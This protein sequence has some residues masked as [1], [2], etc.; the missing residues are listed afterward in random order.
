MYVVRK[1]NA[2][3]ARSLY[4]PSI[5]Q[6]LFVATSELSGSSST[7]QTDDKSLRFK[8]LLTQLLALKWWGSFKLIF[9]VTFGNNGSLFFLL[10][11]DIFFCLFYSNFQW[12]IQACYATLFNSWKC[13]GRLKFNKPQVVHLPTV[14]TWPGF[15]IE[16]QA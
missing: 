12:K 7:I 9:N 1:V 13:R 11:V 16:L 10:L 5:P 3:K 6:L 2:R 4:Q 8:M 14:I 15:I